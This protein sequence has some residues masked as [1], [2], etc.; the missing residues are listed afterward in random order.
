MAVSKC[1]VG[2]D[3]DVTFQFDRNTGTCVNN[4][5]NFLPNCTAAGQSPDPCGDDP[6]FIGYL[7]TDICDEWF[8]CYEGVA[9]DSGNCDCGYEFGDASI[10]CKIIGVGD[11]HCDPAKDPPECPLSGSFSLKPKTY[12]NRSLDEYKRMYSLH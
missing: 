3:L 10:Q 9:Y 4:E 8:F 6:T 7:G 11:T 12:S 5:E 2:P 1:L